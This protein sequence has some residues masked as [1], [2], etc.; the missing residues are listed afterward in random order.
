M[1]LLLKLADETNEQIMKYVEPIQEDIANSKQIIDSSYQKL[2]T[3]TQ[4]LRNDQTITNDYLLNEIQNLSGKVNTLEEKIYATELENQS[5]KNEVSDLKVR[6]GQMDQDFNLTLKSL[7]DSVEKISYHISC[8]HDKDAPNDSSSNNRQSS[9]SRTRTTTKTPSN[10]KNEVK[11]LANKSEKGNGNNRQKL[12]TS[13]REDPEHGCC[14]CCLCSESCSCMSDFCEYIKT[15]LDKMDNVD[16]LTNLNSF[17]IN[18]IK[19]EIEI[20]KR[21][22]AITLRDDLQ[23]INCKFELAIL[24]LHEQFKTLELANTMKSRPPLRHP[25][26]DNPPHSY[27]TTNWEELYVSKGHCDS[28]HHSHRNCSRLRQVF[29]TQ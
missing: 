3:E 11:T 28:D 5:L 12:T 15:K 2:S 13:I 10:L 26:T 9:K 6:I 22:L 20:F 8:M 21:D 4:A 25:A 14:S 29:L 19:S 27:E 7:S 23:A 17:H 24:D 1:D 16:V 18:E